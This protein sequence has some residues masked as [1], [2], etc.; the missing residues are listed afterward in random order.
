MNSTDFSMYSRGD[1][2]VEIE[3]VNPANGID[4]VRPRRIENIQ[5]LGV[6]R[7]LPVDLMGAPGSVEDEHGC[8]SVSDAPWI[9]RALAEACG[10]HTQECLPQYVIVIGISEGTRERVEVGLSRPRPPPR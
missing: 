10:S 8:R 6:P 3:V 2:G 4:S 7:Q 9:G 5:D 1:R